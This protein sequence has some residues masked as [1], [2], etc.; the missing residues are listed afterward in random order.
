MIS[1]EKYLMAFWALVNFS[2]MPQ[3]EWD[4]YLGCSSI[5]EARVCWARSP[6]STWNDL[7]TCA[8]HMKRSR[9]RFPRV[10]GT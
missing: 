6:W 2:G 4:Y 10:N 8:E 1:R 7:T 3:N 9:Y 5:Q